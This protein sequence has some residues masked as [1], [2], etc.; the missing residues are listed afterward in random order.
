MKQSIVLR[1]IGA[2][3]IGAVAQ[4]ACAQSDE[5]LSNI[6][7]EPFA[8]GGVFVSMTVGEATTRL[9]ALGFTGERCAYQREVEEAAG[10]DVVRLDTRRAC[11]E[12]ALVTGMVFIG[13]HVGSFYG[14]ADAD[15]LMARLTG[16]LGPGKRCNPTAQNHASCTWNAPDSTPLAHS[17]SAH[18]QPGRINLKVTSWPTHERPTG[19]FALK[20][21]D[22]FGDM[23]PAAPLGI[24]P[25]MTL[26]ELDARLVELGFETVFD[27]GRARCRWE[28]DLP[29]A[30]RI[31]ISS[32]APARCAPD[33]PME[34]LVIHQ[35]ERRRELI[36]AAPEP[37]EMRRRFVAVLGAPSG[38]QPCPEDVA[39]D[40][41]V[42]CEWNEPDLGGIVHARTLHSPGNLERSGPSETF[43]Y[44]IDYPGGDWRPPTGPVMTAAER[45]AANVRA[46][47]ERLA[48]EAAAKREACGEPDPEL[49]HD[50]R[51][52]NCVL[53]M[54]QTRR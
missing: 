42:T 53:A 26:G 40:E 43:E 18:V 25:G 30:A 38:S 49:V 2:A 48:A 50:E 15:D 9:E 32:G 36:A 54:R 24:A 4:A 51:Y 23:D 39:A 1:A 37:A 31:G 33:N 46:R 19:R 41:R 29:G 34:K 45:R 6:P 28:I 10:S 52:V 5:V 47:E 44:Q 13:L 17:V 11:R 20:G 27:G 22:P 8:D 7:V 3:L 14:A 16:V 35:V 12:D 21:P